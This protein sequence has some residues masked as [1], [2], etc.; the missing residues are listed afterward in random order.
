MYICQYQDEPEAAFIA[1]DLHQACG[2]I[3]SLSGGSLSSLE[4]GNDG[5]M[6]IWWKG[7]ANELFSVYCKKSD[8]VVGQDRSYLYF[9]PGLAKQS[10][11]A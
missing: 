8:G 10:D 7:S 11:A 2:E 4:S 9:V 3:E 6:T 5:D 1:T